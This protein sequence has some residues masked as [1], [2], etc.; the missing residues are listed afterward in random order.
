MCASRN[1]ER[2]VIA[3]VGC[4]RCGAVVGEE[5]KHKGEHLG[6]KYVAVGDHPFTHRERRQAWQ[7]L[8]DI[9][10][11]DAIANSRAQLSS[12]RESGVDAV[13]PGHDSKISL[14]DKV[15][16]AFRPRNI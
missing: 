4:P 9:P 11:L 10:P 13:S 1:R 16:K 2:K 3:A 7:A 5:C 8:K 15:R 12:T 6:I 14:A